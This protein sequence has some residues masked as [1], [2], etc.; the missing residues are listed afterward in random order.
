M[1]AIKK[2]MEVKELSINLQNNTINLITEI[3]KLPPN[4]KRIILDVI[5]KSVTFNKIYNS[6]IMILEKLEL[7]YSIIKKENN[8]IINTIK[9][10][11]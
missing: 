1:K 5:Y 3:F 7:N 8:Q 11:T 2:E 6:I 4:L 10:T 9:E